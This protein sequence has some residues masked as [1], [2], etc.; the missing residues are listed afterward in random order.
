[1]RTGFITTLVFLSAYRIAPAQETRAI[2]VRATQGYRFTVRDVTLEP[3]A[4]IPIFRAIVD[5][6]E[7]GGMDAVTVEVTARIQCGD[8]PTTDLKFT[9]SLGDLKPGKN[10]VADPIVSMR[11]ALASPNCVL[12]DVVTMT[13]TKGTFLSAQ[14]VAQR[15]AARAALDEKVTE[16]IKA[17]AE[18]KAAR[19]AR[20]E[21]ERKLRDQQ[22]ETCSEVYQQTVNKKVS[23]LTVAEDR[24]VKAC[25]ALGYYN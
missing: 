8:A 15:N 12:K 2:E 23:E 1:M 25:E 20:A 10:S 21:A 19:E 18:A 5:A 17:D 24:A 7:T 16:S 14:A 22:I 11:S 6:P 13:F 4:G 3:K 9:A